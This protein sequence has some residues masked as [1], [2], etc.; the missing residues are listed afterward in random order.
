MRAE[1]PVQR[2]GAV[3]GLPGTRQAI[4]PLLRHPQGTILVA[5]R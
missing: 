1:Q 4:L 5:S 2:G 3:N